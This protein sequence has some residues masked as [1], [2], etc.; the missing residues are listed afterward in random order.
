MTLQ[1]N[2]SYSGDISSTSRLRQLEEWHA[3][4]TNVIGLPSTLYMVFLC[5]FYYMYAIFRLKLKLRFRS[6]L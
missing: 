1:Y 5:L 2:T 3:K 4:A 6:M